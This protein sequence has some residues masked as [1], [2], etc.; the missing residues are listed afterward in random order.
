MVQ[1]Q[2][3]SMETILLPV[4]GALRLLLVCQ[5]PSFSVLIPAGELHQRLWF[6]DGEKEVWGGLYFGLGEWEEKAGCLLVHGDGVGWKRCVERCDKH[7]IRV[8]LAHAV[9]DPNSLIN[10]VSPRPP[11]HK[12]THHMMNI[13]AKRLLR[14]D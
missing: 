12:N 9:F 3:V 2:T 6:V 5:T 4:D 1:F 13:Y 8:H 10:S 11:L 7:A 14:C